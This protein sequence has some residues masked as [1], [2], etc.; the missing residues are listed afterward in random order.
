MSLV[1]RLERVE[2]ADIKTIG[3]RRL[4]QYQGSAMPLLQLENYIQATPNPE[5]ESYFVIV[6]RAAKREA[7]LLV[8]VLDDI[9]QLAPEIDDQTFRERGVAGAFVINGETIRMIDVVDLAQ[10]AYPEW[11]E[12]VKE[13][14]R[15]EGGESPLIL[16]A[17]DSTFFR[18]QVC[19]FLTTSGFRVVG[20][21]D[22]AKAWDLLAGPPHDVQLVITDIE[23]PNMNGFELT[24]RIKQHAQLRQLPVIALT[25]LASEADVAQ[26]RQAG[27]DDY[28]VKMDREQVLEAVHR[29]LPR[30]K[31]TL[32]PLR[33]ASRSDAATPCL[34]A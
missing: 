32:P 11:F 10:L 22:G 2:A 17:E 27:I 23:M 21:E 16:I 14:T 7:G 33:S 8:P 15:S 9:R 25:S 5:L 24:R 29:L 4:L 6:F 12:D 3:G 30:S 13:Q 31:Q 20:C 19:E 26:G 28:Q 1:C 34:S 18:K